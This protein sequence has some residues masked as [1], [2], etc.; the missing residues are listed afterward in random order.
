MSSGTGLTGPHARVLKERPGI[1]AA[2]TTCLAD[3]PWLQ[4]G[5]PDVVTSLA[6]VDHDGMRALVIGA[7]ADEPGRAGLAHL[8]QRDY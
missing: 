4:I 1:R 2:M 8:S 3:E 7:I 5:E 6:S